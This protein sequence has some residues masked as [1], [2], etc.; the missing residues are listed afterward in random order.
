M[1]TLL[2]TADYRSLR[3][4]QSQLAGQQVETPSDPGVRV[5]P[6]AGGISFRRV[7]A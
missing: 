3:A 4:V 1:N 6:G 7:S 2:Q 5:E